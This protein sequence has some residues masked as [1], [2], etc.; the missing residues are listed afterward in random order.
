MAKGEGL[1]SNVLWKPPLTPRKDAGC[2]DPWTAKGQPIHPGPLSAGQSADPAGRFLRTNDMKKMLTAFLPLCL[3]G[4]SVVGMQSDLEQP[5]Y[6]VVASLSDDTE[7][8]QYAE[9]IAVEATVTADDSDDARNAAFR[10]LFD[11]ISGANQANAEISMTVPVETASASKR[12]EM[13][14]PVESQIGDAGTVTM[15]FFLPRRFTPESAPKP[16]D[17]RLRLVLMPEQRFAV[18]TFSGSRNQQVVSARVEQL[19]AALKARDLNHGKSAR[20]FFYD[21]PWT[22]PWFRRNEVAIEVATES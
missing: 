1:R 10:L 17:D 16:T 12:I 18:L 3:V 20:A 6:E 22:L 7:I 15:R 19:R 21:P 4:C 8:R 9:R 2:D 11:Y 13:T 14:A 5:P